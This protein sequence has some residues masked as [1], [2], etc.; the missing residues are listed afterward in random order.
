MSLV[1][2]SFASIIHGV[3]IQTTLIVFL[4]TSV[5]QITNSIPNMLHFF[6][7]YQSSEYIYQ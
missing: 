2:W 4:D 1:N 3:T 7:T 5:L 6:Y